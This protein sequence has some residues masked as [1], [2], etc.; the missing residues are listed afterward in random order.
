M[1]WHAA[2]PA[3][4][5]QNHEDQVVVFDHTESSRAGW[6]DETL[7][8]NQKELCRVSV[9]ELSKA[10][11]PIEALLLLFSFFVVFLFKTGSL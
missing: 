2:I 9:H 4:G 1:A 10:E 3:H 8:Q 5:R 11:G 6:L 7:S